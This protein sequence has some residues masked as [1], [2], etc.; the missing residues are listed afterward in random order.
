MF[1]ILLNVAVCCMSL[2]AAAPAFAKGPVKQVDVHSDEW[3]RH[4]AIEESIGRMQ[5]DDLI[6]TIVDTDGRHPVKTQ[7]AAL[8]KSNRAI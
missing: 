2:T 8:I 6:A 4:R 3:R 1:K 7:R 5:L